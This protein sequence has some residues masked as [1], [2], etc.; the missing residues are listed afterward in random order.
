LTIPL[1]PLACLAFLVVL[2]VVVIAP[3]RVWP[4][5]PTLQSLPDRLHPPAWLSGGQ[6]SHPLGF[7]NLGRDVLS[8]VVYGARASVEVGLFSVIIGCSLGTTLGVLSGFTGGR[9]DTAIMMLAD[10]QLAVPFVLL[11]IAVVAVLGPNLVNL[12]LVIGIG[13][14]ANYTRIIRSLS[15]G[16]RERD[17]VQAGRCLGAS[18]LRI[19]GLHIVPNLLPTVIILG[20]LEFARAILTESTLS[21]LGLGVQPPQPS[22][23]SMIFTGTTYLATAWWIALFPGLALLLV[24]IAVNQVGDWLK[25]WLDHDVPY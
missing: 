1:L 11:A 3:E 16:L 9:L 19:I 13:S 6:G 15:L 21:F 5:D 7:D 22:W 8:R 10:I 23:G 17:F 12:I 14:W 18:D 24:G 4:L 2:A 25:D 20:T